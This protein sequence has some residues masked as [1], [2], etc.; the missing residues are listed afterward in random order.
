MFLEGLCWAS[1]VQ[2]MSAGQHPPPEAGVELR[3][4]GA[5]SGCRV[6]GKCKLESQEKEGACEG[7]SERAKGAQREPALQEPDKIKGTDRGARAR[8]RGHWRSREEERALLLWFCSQ[9]TEAR[10]CEC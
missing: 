4:G 8:Q 9:A 5:C 3:D 1:S 7:A 2:K 6:R 10:M